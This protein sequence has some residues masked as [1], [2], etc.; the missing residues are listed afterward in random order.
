MLKFARRHSVFYSLLY[1][2]RLNSILLFPLYLLLADQKTGSRRDEEEELYTESVVV[3]ISDR[4]S[5]R[6]SLYSVLG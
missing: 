4:R 1:L 6:H 2:N 3:Y 5:R